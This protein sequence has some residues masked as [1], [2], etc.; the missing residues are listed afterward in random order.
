MTGTAVLFGLI[1]IGFSWAIWLPLAWTG[2]ESPLKDVGAF[3]PAVA[4]L[5]IV[6]IDLDR[7]RLVMAQLGRW[8]V[9]VRWYALAI[10]APVVACLASVA[11]AGL[12]GASDLHFNDPAQ[13]YL[14]V[15][16]FL[17]VLIA[18][19]PLAE[20]PG[21]RGVLQPTLAE[22]HS[23]PVAGL[24]VGVIWA[25][26]H[27][28]LFMIPGTPQAQLPLLGYV[29][30]TIGL[31]VIYGALGRRTGGSLPVAIVLHAASNTAAGVLPVVPSEAG[32][33]LLPFAL[34]TGI[35]LTVAGSIL[36][37][38]AR[39]TRPGVHSVGMGVR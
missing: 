34:V 22:R 3:G 1:A 39:S 5:V 21:W 11:A 27:L 15:P 4:T 17:V 10:G 31:G 30:L 12:L 36:A 8:R 37:G 20:E 18:G 24:V 29:P 9:P 35:V 16:A 19:G 2:T 14:I 7:R 33:P 32:G 38:T 6:A 26:W 25:V 13:L 23:A 28:P